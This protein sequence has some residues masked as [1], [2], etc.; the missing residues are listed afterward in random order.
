MGYGGGF[1][2]SHYLYTGFTWHFNDFTNASLALISGFDDISFT[3]VVS[4]NHEVFQ[5]GTLIFSAQIPLDRDLFSND[6]N[7]GELG[8][9]PPDKLQPHT[10][11]NQ[12][13]GRFGRYFDCSIK[14]RLR[15]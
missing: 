14:L 8:P 7:R 15:F 1:S 11:E 5:G 6:G 12:L 2:N 3:P 13:I 4:V 9:L 10:P